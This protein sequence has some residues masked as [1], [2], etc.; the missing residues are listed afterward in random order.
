MDE[1]RRSTVTQT[2]IKWIFICGM[3]T[4][5]G[6]AIFYAFRTVSPKTEM[7]YLNKTMLRAEI[8]MTKNHSGKV[9]PG[10]LELMRIMPC[11]LYLTITIIIKCG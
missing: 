7:I 3:L 2:V 1:S 5:I 6:G 9:C 8:A 10:G 11:C 4:V